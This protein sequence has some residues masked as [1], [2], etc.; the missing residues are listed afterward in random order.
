MSSRASYQIPSDNWWKRDGSGWILLAESSKGSSGKTS[1]YLYLG[2]HD[3]E[4]LQRI[5]GTQTC[6]RKVEGVVWGGLRRISLV[7]PKKH[8]RNNSEGTVEV[9]PSPLDVH[10]RP[11]IDELL[12]QS[13]YGRLCYLIHFPLPPLFLLLPTT[14]VPSFSANTFPQVRWSAR[15]HW[16]PLNLSCW[17]GLQLYQVCQR[18]RGSCSM[19]KLNR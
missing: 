6:S 17:V 15:D 5:R 9:I 2:S 12:P 10:I 18:L 8:K 14:H 11:S 1:A 7:G 16:D 19:E 13:K 3:R 4:H